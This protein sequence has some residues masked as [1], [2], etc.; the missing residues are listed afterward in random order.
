MMKRAITRR[1]TQ[2]RL[3]AMG[4]RHELLSAQCPQLACSATHHS[5]SGLQ[6]VTAKTD[7]GSDHLSDGQHEL[8]AGHTGSSELH[9]RDLGQIQR[10]AGVSCVPS[11][12]GFPA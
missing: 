6:G 2:T 5:R 12:V 4:T 3:V 9:G 7:T 1:T 11:R 10:G 8:P